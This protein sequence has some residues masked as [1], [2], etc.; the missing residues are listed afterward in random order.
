MG[1]SKTGYYLRSGRGAV[2]TDPEAS[3]KNELI[4]DLGD[5][6]ALAIDGA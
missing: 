3:N 1:M 5:L 2:T 4:T 6:A